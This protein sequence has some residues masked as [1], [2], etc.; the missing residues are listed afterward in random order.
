MLQVVVV[1][2]FSCSKVVLNQ[3]HILKT[4][5]TFYMRMCVIMKV[6]RGSAGE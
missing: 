2:L 1:T 3:G 4:G 6:L 5:F